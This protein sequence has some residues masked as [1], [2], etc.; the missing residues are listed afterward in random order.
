MIIPCNDII[1]VWLECFATLV[2]KLR[3]RIKIKSHN[4]NVKNEVNKNEKYILPARFEPGMS[5]LECRC[6]TH[7]Y[8]ISIYSTYGG[9][10]LPVTDL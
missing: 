1:D 2:T 8:E 5:W 6:T 3:P 7:R 9:L 4:K 10:S